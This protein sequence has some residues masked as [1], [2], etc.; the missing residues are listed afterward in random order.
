MFGRLIASGLL[1]CSV[2]ACAELSDQMA[3]AKRNLSNKDNWSFDRRDAG[4]NA[5]PAEVATTH[6]HCES[7]DDEVASGAATPEE[8][9]ACFQ[10]AVARR[11]EEALL[12]LTC[13]GKT[14]ANC[15][16]S[17]AD[18][19]EAKEWLRDRTQLAWN[20]V[21]GRYVVRLDQ[22]LTYVID[23]WP[24]SSR[25]SAVSVCKIAEKPKAPGVPRWAVCDIDELARDAAE[26]R[27]PPRQAQ[28]VN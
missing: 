23:T 18:H 27:L 3:Q 17:S 5:K 14:S 4:T 10:E 28:A 22:E 8:L 19:A 7:P 2:G 16:H 15:K 13:H 21:L 9:I 26:R 24:S 6:S 25:V 20:K 11:S 12:A 1:L